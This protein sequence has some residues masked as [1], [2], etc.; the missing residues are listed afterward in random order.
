MKKIINFNK[1]F[2]SFFL[3][4]IMI[5]SMAFKGATA[6]ASSLSMT[7]A[8]YNSSWA[9]EA[10]ISVYVSGSTSIKVTNPNG[11]VSKGD[12]YVGSNYT[13]SANGTYKFTATDSS[14]ANTSK[15][16]TISNIDTT[17]PNLILAQSKANGSTTIT[18]TASDNGS[19]VATITKPDGSVV[20]GA[21]A[22]Y[23]IN[24]NSNGVYTFSSAD[25]LGNTTTQSITVNNTS[26]TTDVNNGDWSAESVTMQN[27]NEAQLMVRVGDIDNF[28]FGWSSVDPFSG[29]ETAVHSF[30]FTPG[31]S[32]PQGTDRIMTVTGYNTKYTTVGTNTDGYTR[33]NTSYA[34]IVNPIVMNYNSYLSG[35]SVQNA[36][37]QMFLDDFQPG[38][39]HGVTQGTVQYTATMNGV[40][41]PELSNLINNLDESGPIGK[42]VTFQIPQRYLDL[43][44]TGSISIKFDDTNDCTGDGYAIDFVKL[45]INK[46]DATNNTATVTGN[47]KDKSNNNN[48]QGATVSAGGVVTTTTDAN[49]N[50]T[51]NNVPAGQAIVTA[52][53]SGYDTATVT[54][55]T[56]IAGGGYTAN[57]T[58]TQ[59]PPPTTPIISATPT[60]L[61]NDKV[62]ATINYSADSSIQQYRVDIGGVTGEWKIY[63]GS[64]DVTQNC[65]IEAQGINQ[66]GNESQIASYTVNNIDTTPPTLTLSESPT[67]STNGTA[68]ITAAATDNVAVANIAKPDSTVV[69]GNSTTYTV[70]ANGT[71]SFTATD[72]A[73][74]ITTQSININNIV[75][76]GTNDTSLPNIQASLESVTPNP[77]K[78]SNDI[79]IKYAINTVPF[80]LSDENID[81]AEVLVDMS[82]AM[83][84]NQ[85]FSEVQNGFVNQ[86]INDSNL[87]NI[88]LG[89]VG[90]NDSV[91]VGMR[92][93]YSDPKSCVMQQ[94]NENLSDINK[95]NFLPLYNLNDA[96]TKDGYRQ[97]YQN[98]Y[99]YNKISTNDQRQFG[100]A[101][102][103]ADN[104]LTNYGTNG[105]RKAIIIISSGNLTYSDDQ[106]ESIIGKGYKIIVLDISNS[107]NTNI[108]DT[109]TRLCGNQFGINGNYYTG[110]FN[111]GANYNSVDA[112][113]KNVDASLKGVTGV[114]TLSINDAKLN[115]DLGENFKAVAGGGLEGTGKVCTVTIPQINFTY[116]ST[117]GLWEQSGSVEVNFKVKSESGKYGQLGFGSYTNVDNTTRT[118]NSTISY[119]NFYDIPISKVIDTPT[120]NITE[121]VKVVPPPPVITLPTDGTS[122]SNNKPTISGTG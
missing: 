84:S 106:I 35:V 5:Y 113:M 120:V 45:L 100:S 66:Y 74:N 59:S 30:P 13:V 79:N 103:A 96:N 27:T 71:Y 32:D 36:T 15:S 93:D 64:F 90:Y 121:D 16:I 68:T 57:F 112:D 80:S 34:K 78:S 67:I 11:T 51:L 52:S 58:L 44:R 40:E 55:P 61:T 33:S 118:N 53:K 97:F 19:G 73:G 60:T 23:S 85:R 115:I 117:T 81:E 41:I 89:L 95:S 38:K 3:A 119:T 24:G 91:Y 62:T 47:V 7:L 94:T 83:N 43:I 108:K 82:Q 1:K 31:N 20:W 42:L 12:W 48:I 4:S 65:V 98:G 22:S 21:K 2:V 18:A 99:I 37:I 110:T 105:A 72:T 70:S 8:T 101:L 28:G 26:S 114:T 86:I 75:T 111:D 102:K 109:Y 63:N 76:T 14:G 46:T 39:A 107:S 54:I 25:K 69:T 29:V 122:T 116:N 56:V 87:S 6:S 104:V 88:K 92:S 10:T 9:K 50:Y 77:A 49:G 17:P